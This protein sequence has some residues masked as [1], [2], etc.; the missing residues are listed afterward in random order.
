MSFLGAG[1]GLVGVTGVTGVILV[2]RAGLGMNGRANGF[3]SFGVK[4]VG[5]RGV[6]V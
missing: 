2:G 4:Y 6:G 1:M 5:P 3:S